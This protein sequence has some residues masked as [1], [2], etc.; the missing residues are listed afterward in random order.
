M[1]IGV[2]LDRVEEVASHLA[3]FGAVWKVFLV[4]QTQGTG[5]RASINRRLRRYPH[6]EVRDPMPLDA[7][8]L[9][10]PSGHPLSN[11]ARCRERLLATARLIRRNR[12]YRCYW[13]SESRNIALLR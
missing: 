13:A 12:E 6:I 3:P 5:V 4:G 7:L 8:P 1:D 10:A 9:E 11:S 2:V